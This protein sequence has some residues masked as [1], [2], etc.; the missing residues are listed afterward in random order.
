MKKKFGKSV[1]QWVQE[2]FLRTSPDASL[3]SYRCTS[4]QG[5]SGERGVKNGCM[6]TCPNDRSDGDGDGD[7][8]L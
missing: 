3:W 6:Y 1:P 4:L 8:D 5:R 2:I 7:G